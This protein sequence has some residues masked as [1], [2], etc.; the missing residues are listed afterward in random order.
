MRG[1]SHGGFA[2]AAACMH[3]EDLE[4]LLS[5]LQ[6]S[7]L[8]QGRAGAGGSTMVCGELFRASG[9]GAAAAT[10][11]G[12]PLLASV[13]LGAGSGRLVSPPGDC[14]SRTPSADSQSTDGTATAGSHTS[15]LSWISDDGGRCSTKDVATA[16]TAPVMPRYSSYRSVPSWEEMAEQASERM[17]AWSRPN[18]WPPGEQPPAVK[19]LPLGAVTAVRAFEAVAAKARRALPRESIPGTVSTFERVKMAQRS[20]GLGVIAS[21]GPGAGAGAPRN[22]AAPG[23]GSSAGSGHRASGP[24]ESSR[25]PPVRRPQALG[26]VGPSTLA[27]RRAQS[28]SERVGRARQT[29]ISVQE[30]ADRLLEEHALRSQASSTANSSTAR[31]QLPVTLAPPALPAPPLHEPAPLVRKPT[32]PRTGLCAHQLGIPEAA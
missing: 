1:G 19:L 17:C 27:A 30:R 24:A 29:A 3:A 4:Y 14:R 26:P 23:C 18:S 31:A 12:A 5:P 28:W 10:Q 13:L 20:G 9:G 11:R 2:G 8:A 16:E 21:S 15:S 6:R 32:T 7:T 25:C 22:A